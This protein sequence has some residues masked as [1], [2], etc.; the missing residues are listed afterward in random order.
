MNHVFKVYD[1]IALHWHHTRGLRKV[2]WHRVKAFLEELP[3]GTLL[4]GTNL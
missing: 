2:Y 3:K 4:A 1:E